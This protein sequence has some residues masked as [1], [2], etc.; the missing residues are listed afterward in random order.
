MMAVPRFSR[1]TALRHAF[2]VAAGSVLLPFHSRVAVANLSELRA[3]DIR[4]GDY[5]TVQALSFMDRALRR[6]S[7]NSRRVRIFAN[8]QLGEEREIIEQV[9]IGIVDIARINIASLVAFIPELGA[10]ATPFLFRSVQHLHKIID[11]PVGQAMLE[12]LEARGFVGLTFLDAGS[13]CIYNRVR[14]VTSAA[15][16]AGLRLRCEHAAIRE[17]SLRALGAVPMQLPHSHV[18]PALNAGLADGAVDNLATYTSSGHHAAA[19]FL[20]LLDYDRSPDIILMSLKAWAAL[21]EEERQSLR[22]AANGARYFMRPVFD[23]WTRLSVGQALEQGV[24][25]IQSP[26]MDSFGVALR[27]HVKTL[28]AGP[29]LRWITEIRAAE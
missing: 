4:D 18:L 19:P 22:D 2:C 11:G 12:S 5:P 24:K 1:R 29:A 23:R 17:E 26:D 3:T 7:K 15:D 20:T 6:D 27:P 21:R 16:V 13:R 8:A 25:I 28:E 10:L 14:P 9:R